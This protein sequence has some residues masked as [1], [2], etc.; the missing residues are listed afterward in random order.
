MNQ[1]VHNQQQQS[2]TA[3]QYGDSIQQPQSAN[4][5]GTVQAQGQVNTGTM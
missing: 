1:I 2:A 5:V 3:H 4:Q